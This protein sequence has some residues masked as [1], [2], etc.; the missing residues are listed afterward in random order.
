[1]GFLRNRIV[2]PIYNADN[3]IINLR[4]YSR[5]ASEKMISYG[6][7]YGTTALFPIQNLNADEILICEGE[8]DCILAN[9][10]GFNAV[11]NT[12]GAKTWKDQWNILFAGKRVNICYDIDAPGK[13]GALKV[14]E[15]LYGYAETVKIIKLPIDPTQIPNGDLTDFVVKL[16]HSKADCDRII[17]S[18]HPWHPQD[19]E[20][21]E[22]MLH[23]A[24][25]AVY[26]RKDVSFT[27]IISGK[28]L[29]PYIVPRKVRAS[30]TMSAGER[31]CSICPLNLNNGE[32]EKTIDF[33]YNNFLLFLDAT[34][35]VKKG[36]LR[37]YFSIPSRC[38]VVEFE[39]L[40]SYNVER[41]IVT[42]EIEYTTSAK[43]DNKYVTR[44]AYY[45]GHD[46]DANRAY[47]FNAI[48]LSHP[49]TQQ[50]TH[51]IYKSE[52]ALTSIDSYSFD[53]DTYEELRKFQ[54]E[55]IA[56]KL[57]EIYD[58]TIE[59]LTGIKNRID[60]FI[61][62][63]LTFTSAL[64]FDF[65]RRRIDKG[66]IETLIL[67][68]TRTGKTE[69]MKRLIEYF[70]A[71]ELVLGES[72]SFAGLVGGIQQIG[73]RWHLTWGRIPLNNRRL[74]AVDE[75]SGLHKYEIA[76]LS[77]IR[78]SGVAEITKIRT[79]RTLSMTRLL[80]MSNPR[81]DYIE[82]R[83]I[84]SYTQGI[85]AVPELIGKPE[86]IS[87]ID[88]LLILSIDEVPLSVINAPNAMRKHKFKYTSDDFHNLIMW[89]WK[90]KPEQ[91]QFAEDAVHLVY[92]F[93]NQ[94]AKKYSQAIPIV[95]S[96]EQRIKLARLAVAVAAATFS[97]DT[98]K[99]LVV[100]PEHVSFVS[101]YLQHIFDKPACAYNEFSRLEKNKNTIKDEQAITSELE[102]RN[103]IVD[104]LLDIERMTFSDIQ[105]IFEIDGRSDTRKLITKFIKL[106]AFKRVG[107]MYEKTPALVSLLR[108]I[109]IQKTAQTQLFNSEDEVPF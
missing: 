42:P 21:V 39:E 9:Q 6:R 57:T 60:L 49:R 66:W 31:M 69:M 100:K 107:Q 32:L 104:Q 48:T 19:K 54:A 41:I 22:V 93:A 62:I 63:F 88:I 106:N 102:Q 33:R 18:T 82:Q 35:N 71:G 26:N 59:P 3:D 78:S 2:I 95:I 34:N 101:D 47:K 109:R 56:A 75:M 92:Y 25:N 98:G 7:G 5:S 30:C 84:S 90:L 81:G 80:W 27:A 46:V 14:A 68:D 96:S 20:L 61:A 13:N 76:K 37:N 10:L 85:R 50:A 105:D 38:A 16:K 52:P 94:F 103:G 11:T 86:D 36:L 44:T 24:S 79:E 15:K 43:D 58:N 70:R 87:R 55:D 65:D 97:T 1:M 45:I 67:G 73:S 17:H 4:M 8:L 91:I 51:L 99:N 77:G 29:A 89:A 64:H 40:E 72:A 53:D 12:A 83:L 108:R 28:D 23:E 74:V